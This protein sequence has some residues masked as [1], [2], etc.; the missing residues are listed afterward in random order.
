MIVE[1]GISQR[2]LDKF[3]RSIGGTVERVRRTGEA[4]YHH[5]TLGRSDR[6]NYRRKDAS[7]KLVSFVNRVTDN[8]R[9]HG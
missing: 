7:V 2:E 8:R 1:R 4:R 6:F 3:W 5:P 9:A